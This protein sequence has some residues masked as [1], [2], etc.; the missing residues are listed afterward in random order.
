MDMTII[1]VIRHGKTEM[2]R[3]HLI[4]G[5]KDS[6]LLLSAERQIKQIANTFKTIPLTAIYTSNLPRAHKT[7][8][9]IKKELSY[10]V[11]LKTSPSLREVDYGK[12]VGLSK[13]IAEKKYPLYHKDVHFVHPSGESFNHMY[14]RIV[15]FFKSIARKKG[16]FL[17][18]THAGCIRALYAYC[19]KKN[20]EKVIT[21]KVSHAF[22]M[23][24][25]KKE[26]ESKI[27]IIHY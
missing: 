19:K 4:L 21:M 11:P 3:K 27:T 26:R 12:L 9:L 22:V 2:N 6:P 14:K 17:L 24:Y 7:A 20:F 8:Q 16:I 10:T 1:Y 15:P 5:H 18:V 13:K 25:T 23:K